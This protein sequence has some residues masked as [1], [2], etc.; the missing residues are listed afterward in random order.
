MKKKLQNS[1]LFR[2]SGPYIFSSFL[3][4]LGKDDPLIIRTLVTKKQL[5]SELFMSICPYI[6]FLFFMLRNFKQFMSLDYDMNSLNFF[7]FSFYR[8]ALSF[9]CRAVAIFSVILCSCKIETNSNS[10]IWY[11]CCWIVYSCWLVPKFLCCFFVE[12]LQTIH[13]AFMSLGRDINSLNFLQFSF[14]RW[15]SSSSCR[16]VTIFSTLL[17]LAIKLKWNL[18]ASFDTWCWLCFSD[19]FIYFPIIC[20]CYKC[21]SSKQREYLKQTRHCVPIH[22][23]MWAA[24]QLPA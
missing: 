13:V 24:Q 16:V 4:K 17:A 18:C 11:T 21:D 7:R 9:S 20:C 23:S 14:Y 6:S 10:F 3:K 22:F 5:N 15:A 19:V 12:E 8:S 2:S 1:E